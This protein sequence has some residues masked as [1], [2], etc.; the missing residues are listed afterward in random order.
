MQSTLQHTDFVGNPSSEHTAFHVLRTAEILTQAAYPAT[1][2]NMVAI[3]QMDNQWK[4]VQLHRSINPATLFPVCEE[5]HNLTL[6]QLAAWE[7]VALIYA[8]ARQNMSAETDTVRGIKDWQKILLAN[9]TIRGVGD[10]LRCLADT[11]LQADVDYDQPIKFSSR[12]ANRIRDS[13]NGGLSAALSGNPA[14]SERVLHCVELFKSYNE[15]IREALWG[16]S[17]TQQ[18][19]STEIFS[20]TIGITVPDSS[21]RS[22]SSQ[23]VIERMPATRSDS[24]IQWHYQEQG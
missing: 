4:R 6:R 3:A 13:L 5:S 23:N 14:F 7:Q 2:R 20:S 1:A 10:D 17:A 12:N 21:G 15:C 19:E 11:L 24:Q 9:D 22:D 8:V 18:T 16:A